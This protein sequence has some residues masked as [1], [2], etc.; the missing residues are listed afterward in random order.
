MRIL[1]VPLKIEVVIHPVI[2]TSAATCGVLVLVLCQ[3]AAAC[4]AAIG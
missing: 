3:S 2:T 1:M 4:L